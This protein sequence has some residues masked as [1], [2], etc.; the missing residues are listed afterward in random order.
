VPAT[1]PPPSGGGPV[2]APLR[3]ALIGYGLAG[4]AFHAPLIA[5]EPALE[6][7]TIVTSNHERAARAR[8]RHPGVV[9]VAGAGEV[10]ERAEGL[11]LAVIAAPNAAHLSLGLA[12]LEAGL[13]VVM[14]KPLALNAADGR[15]LERAAAERGRVLAAFHNRR[16]DGDFLTLRRLVDAGA[17]GEVTRL[18]SRFERWR[19]EVRSGAWRERAAAA[20]G[21][22][23]LLDLGSH[24][25]DQA[26]VL[27][28]PVEAVYAEL[29]RRRAAAGA[30]D[31]DFVAL[32]HRSGARSHLW[33]SHA[34]AQGGPRFRVQ[35]S[36]AAWVKQGLD[37]Q[38]A[39]LRGGAV[40]GG[41]GWGEEPPER[42]G[43]L[44]A[45]AELR[46]VPTEPGDYPRFY[47]ELVRAI[48][49]GGP[50]PVS[51][52]EAVAGLAV[53]EAARESARTGDVTAP[54]AG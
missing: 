19:P 52:G 31:D 45:G 50:P 20:E 37:V 49:E 22:G 27:L 6:L 26:L 14:D 46:P 13:H 5:A 7:A 32:R 30:D 9:V 35:G 1:G 51:A 4:E 47:R 28:G 43:L 12:A 34:A 21:G 36:R 42:W 44:G 41:P 3:T 17:L 11:H 2:T 53:I 18:E 33:M 29:D 10:W 23:L 15:R 48:R 8:K 39:A 25:V 24:L 16:L 38:E 54:A 40:P